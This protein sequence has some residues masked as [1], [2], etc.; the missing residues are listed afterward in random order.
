MKVE[1]KEFNDKVAVSLA[2]EMDT[3]AAM[4]MEEN[5]KSLCDTK[6]KEIVFDCTDLEYIASSGLRILLSIL[7]SAKANGGNVVLQ[8]VN[9]D[10]KDVFQLTGFI[11]IFTIE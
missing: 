3:A 5:L 4:E 11:N 1:I 2:G 9:E 7:K 8:H 6:G 10:I